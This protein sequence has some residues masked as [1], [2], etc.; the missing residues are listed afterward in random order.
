MT[1]YSSV[2]TR[3]NGTEATVCVTR[4]DIRDT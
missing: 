4:R 3:H 1:A 2:H